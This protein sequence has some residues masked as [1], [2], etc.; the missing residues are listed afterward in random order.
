MTEL[1]VYDLFEDVYEIGNQLA[2]GERRRTKA[3]L[4]KW[5]IISY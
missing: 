2:N 3:I 5:T 1:P 4:S